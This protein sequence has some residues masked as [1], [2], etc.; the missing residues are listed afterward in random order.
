MMQVGDRSAGYTAFR[1]S[2]PSVSP[3]KVDFAEQFPIDPALCYLN[4]AAIGVWPQRTAEAVKA[5][6]EENLT[7]GATRWRDW[8]TK[9]R[10]MRDR[11]ARLTNAP[12]ADDIALLKNT[13]EA[14]SVVAWGLPWQAGDNVVL[15]AQ[16][17]PSNRIVWESLDRI[18]VETRIVNIE[19]TDDPEALLVEAIDTRTRLLTV[20]SVQYGDGLRMD[21]ERLG[22]F[23]GGNDILFCVDAIQSLGVLPFDVKTC[24]ADFVMADGHKWLLGPEG[25]TVFYCREELRE[26]LILHQYG[27]RMVENPFD[28]E[29]RDWKPAGTARRFEAGSGNTLGIYAQEA[30][31]S[32]LQE[33][34]IEEVARLAL[35]NSE[36]LCQGLRKIKGVTILSDR[37]E[38]RRSPIVTFSVDGR[39]AGDIHRLLVKKGVICAVRGGGIRLAPHFYTPRQTLDRALEVIESTLTDNKSLG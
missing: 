32:L 19:G 38:A 7:R 25:V 34:G 39:D 9:E 35:Q 5:F 3:M 27:W 20:S 23:C 17:F 30:S 12:S 11:F 15:A 24:Q 28:M 31:L 10:A 26:Q 29:R 18:G 21:V 37:R 22:E 6:A 14:L 4:H 13:S 8:S 33:I 2:T 1:A 16:E 36:H